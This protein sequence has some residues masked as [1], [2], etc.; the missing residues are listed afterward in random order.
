ME[1]H[2]SAEKKIKELSVK[3]F[4]ELISSTLRETLEELLEDKEA[5]ASEKYINSIREAR[6]EYRTGKINKLEF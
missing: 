4:Q 1:T 2:L 3:E 6:E 5:L